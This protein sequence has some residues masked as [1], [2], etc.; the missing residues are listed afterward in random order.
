MLEDQEIQ[1]LIQKIKT[2]PVPKTPPRITLNRDGFEEGLKLHPDANRARDFIDKLFKSG[3]NITNNAIATSGNPNNYKL[4]KKYVK[5]ALRQIDDHLEKQSLWGPFDVHEIPNELQDG[6]TWP[7]FFRDE[8][9][10]TRIKYRMLINMSDELEDLPLNGF[11]DDDEKTIVYQTITQVC[12]WII[13]LRL[14]FLFTADVKDAFHLIPI[15]RD[16]IKYNGIQICGLLFFWTTLVFGLASSCAIWGE[17]AVMISW[18]IINNEVDIFMYKGRELLRQ[19]ADDWIGGHTTFDLAMTQFKRLLFWWKKLGI[20]F[21]ENKLVSPKRDVD[22]IGYN[23]ETHH[24]TLGLSQKRLSKYSKTIMDILH[25][26]NQKGRAKVTVG[27]LR[28][29][30]GQLRSTTV[31]YPLIVPWIRPFEGLICKYTEKN[32]KFKLEKLTKK[33]K[34]FLLKLKEMLNDPIL[35]RRKM[36]HVAKHQQTIDYTIL[37]DAS[38]TKGMGGFIKETKGE[39]FKLMW[40]EL[41]Q[42]EHL[43][44]K[45]D[46]IWMELAAVVTAIGLF[47]NKCRASTVLVKCDNQTVVG[48]VRRKTACLKRKD[49]LKLVETLC[50]YLLKYHIELKI[51]HIPGVKNVVADKLSRDITDIDF[52]LASAST[53]CSKMAGNYMQQ[54]AVLTSQRNKKHCDC[55]NLFVCNRHNSLFN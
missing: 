34:E 40:Q 15:N 42:Y 28:T 19:Y 21:D 23:L 49:L 48:I 8:S 6:A 12:E 45:P 10:E 7:I 50:V 27:L 36:Q 43:N 13:S 4:C 2:K 35:K 38:T 26:F 9:D 32:D 46:I 47:G 37:T 39:Y 55:N 5:E 14:M 44:K 11:V 29:L 33:H 16:Q 51:V 52:D 3:W 18:I 53:P 17:F 25:S 41:K 30:V 54:Y 31:V 20:P 22:Y 24:Y 1:D